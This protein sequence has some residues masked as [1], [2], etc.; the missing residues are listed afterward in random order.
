MGQVVVIT[1][2]SSGIGRT[3]AEYLAGRGHTV[4]GCSRRTLP[5]KPPFRE[6]RLD[7]TDGDSVRSV[8]REILAREKRLDVLV[9]N[10]GYGIAGAVEECS[11]GESRAQFDTNFFGALSMIREVAPSMRQAGGGLI[12]NIGSIGGML[13]LPF[14]GVYS[15]TKFALMGLTESLRL[16]LAPFNVRV[17]II[18]PGDFA[19][20]FT[21]NRRTCAASRGDSPYRAQFSRAVV[22]MERDERR[23]AAPI[24]V[25]RLI[26]GIMEKKSPK[27]R[28]TV[29]RMEQTL[30]AAIG[31]ILPSGLLNRIVARHYGL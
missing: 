9:N 1:G 17:S 26:E 4:Y 6:L 11:D 12:I 16:E 8:V 22:R 19:T 21:G 10:A 18:C 7:V 24:L 31:K 15:A 23:G 2:A 5:E 3:C 27:V 30:F 20:G 25:A 28:Y 29:G 13:G 14:Q